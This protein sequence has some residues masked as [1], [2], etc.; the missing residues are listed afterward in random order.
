MSTT[1]QDLKLGEYFPRMKGCE[2]TGKSFFKCFFERGKMEGDDD[3]VAGQRALEVCRREFLSYEKC[4]SRVAPK[5]K[6]SVKRYRVSLKY[7]ILL[8]LISSRSVY[9]LNIRT[10]TVEDFSYLIPYSVAG[11]RR[12]PREVRIIIM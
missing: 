4:M 10:M 2:D 9:P 11:S 8:C 1:S 6:L 7:N 5:D 12:V 3:A